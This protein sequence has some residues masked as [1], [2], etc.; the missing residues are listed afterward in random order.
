MGCL[1]CMLSSGA[2]DSEWAEAGFPAGGLRARGGQGAGE[3]RPAASRRH[4]RVPGGGGP[5]AGI[6][7]GAR[8]SMWRGDPSERGGM[9]RRERILG[10][11]VLVVSRTWSRRS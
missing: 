9:L 6:P 8:C 1:G 10:A 5:K 2:R 3:K 7:S 4:H 11:T